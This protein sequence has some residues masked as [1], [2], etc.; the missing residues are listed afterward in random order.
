MCGFV[1][2]FDIAKDASQY[3]DC[4]KEMSRKIRHRGPDWSGIFTGL[5]CVDRKSVV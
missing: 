3:R 1:G 2:M 5:D 4:V